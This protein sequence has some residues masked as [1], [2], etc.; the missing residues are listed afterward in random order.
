MSFG[1]MKYYVSGLIMLLV[2]LLNAEAQTVNQEFPDQFLFP[3]FSVGVVTIKNGGKTILNLNYNIVT[4]KMVFMQKGQIFDIVNDNAIDTVYILE[5]KFVPV[6]KVFYEV[7]IRGP[8]SFFIQHKGTLGSPARPAAYGG[9]SQVSSSTYISNM[10]LGN[11]VYRIKKSDELTIIPGPLY[12][13]GNNGQMKLISKKSHLLNAFYDKKEE[14]REFIS[15]NK[16]DFEN[17]DQIKNLVNY[18]N[19]LSR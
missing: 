2:S 11:D 18:Y 19:G 1:R 13:I 6:K 15:K 7:I 9:T 8:A 17:P 10:R 3:A 4:E 5:R 12:W 16:T 14:I